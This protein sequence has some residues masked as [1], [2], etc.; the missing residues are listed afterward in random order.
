MIGKCFGLFNLVFLLNFLYWLNKRLF[1]GLLFLN[2]F[3]F[4]TLRFAFNLNYYFVCSVSLCLLIYLICKCEGSFVYWFPFVFSSFEIIKNVEFL[5]IILFWFLFFVFCFSV[6][7]FEFC[8]FNVL[9]SVFILCIV[10][11]CIIIACLLVVIDRILMLLLVVVVMVFVVV[12]SY[13][14][15]CCCWLYSF[16]LCQRRLPGILALSELKIWLA[17]EIC[18]KNCVNW[19]KSVYVEHKSMRVSY[20]MFE[21]PSSGAKNLSRQTS[22]KLLA[23]NCFAD[24]LLA[25][26]FCFTYVFSHWTAGSVQ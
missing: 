16:C 14:S 10:E 23:C 3:L 9:V 5:W 11:S 12:C 6:F 26:Y 2:F 8:Y 22:I 20:G 18:I 24:L 4:F 13:C 19:R 25:I 21:S 15:C 17:F 7:T 1:L